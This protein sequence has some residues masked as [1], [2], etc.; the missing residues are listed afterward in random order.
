MRRYGWNNKTRPSLTAGFYE[1]KCW[2]CEERNVFII[3]P[4]TLSWFNSPLVRKILT[5]PY[6]R[7]HKIPKKFL[8]DST[9]K[10]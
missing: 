2:A 1:I 7:A 9:R 4:K 6:Y 8:G 10:P 5:S 3:D